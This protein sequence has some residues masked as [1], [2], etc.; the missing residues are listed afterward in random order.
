MAGQNLYVT[1]FHLFCTV[2]TYGTRIRLSPILFA[3][4]AKNPFVIEEASKKCKNK[5]CLIQTY[6][7]KTSRD[8]VHLLTC[9]Q[10]LPFV[11]HKIWRFFCVYI[12]WIDK[13]RARICNPFKEPSNQFPAWRNQ[14]LGSIK[15]LKFRALG[16][17]THLNGW[18]KPVRNSFSLVLYECKHMVWNTLKF[19]IK[20]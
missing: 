3:L 8:T 18:T 5:L 13:A 15:G 10:F 12:E 4:P 17:I 20:N 11:G 7:Y 6:V 1:L 2:Q 14:F 16:L 9:S 19:L